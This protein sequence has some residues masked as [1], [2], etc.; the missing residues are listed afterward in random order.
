M[1]ASSFLETILGIAALSFFAIL[2]Y[3]VARS[4]APKKADERPADRFP[5]NDIT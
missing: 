3:F 2:I 1:A 4:H 5:P